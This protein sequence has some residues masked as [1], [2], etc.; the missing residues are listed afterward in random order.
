VKMPFGKHKG[1]PVETLPR[2]YL[3]WL[4]RAVDL[5]GDLKDAVRSAL[6]GEPIPTAP[7]VDDLV[8]DFETQLEA[9]KKP[10]GIE[11]SGRNKD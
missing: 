7:D 3:K 4:E 1:R 6:H 11:A 9:I 8:V 10:D 2:S 5:R